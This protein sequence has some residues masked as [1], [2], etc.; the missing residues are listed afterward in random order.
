MMAHNTTAWNGWDES[1]RD[2]ITRM[3]A[4][5]ISRFNAYLCDPCAGLFD[6]VIK[7]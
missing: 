2:T 3:E 7:A 1:H 6:D 4:D 5:L